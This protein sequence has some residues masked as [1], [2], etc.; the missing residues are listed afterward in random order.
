MNIT[1][2]S[3]LLSIASLLLG[4]ATLASIIG[5]FLSPS[6]RTKLGQASYD[7]LLSAIGLLSG[8][9]IL[10]ALV[11]QFIYLAPTCSLCWWQRIFIFPIALIVGIA[12]YTRSKTDHLITGA[13]A[14]IG[15]FFASYHYYGHFQK[16]VLG[17]PFLIPCSTSALEPSCSESPIIIFG[18]VTIPLMGVFALS[19]MIWL[20]YLAH[21]KA[22]TTV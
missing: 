20:S 13:L 1:T 6:I 9:S 12:L 2:Y 8:F 17:N 15:L 5:Y 11:Y 7:T 19:A 14:L 22:K 21:Q 18:F 3:T 16:Y 4:A 10:G